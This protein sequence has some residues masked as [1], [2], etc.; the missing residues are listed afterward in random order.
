MAARWVA[1][2]LGLVMLGIVGF[3]VGAVVWPPAA[4]RPSPAFG[5]DGSEARAAHAVG[6]A[7][8]WTV[9]AEVAPAQAGAV[10]I[11][12]SIADAEGRPADPSTRPTA[13]LRMGDDMAMGSEVVNLVPQAP[14][15]WRGSGR[16]SMAGRWRLELEVEGG[17]IMLPLSP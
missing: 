10:E 13:V 12:V 2:A 5:G 4:P 1:L 17:R 6:Q 8:R 7:G 14:G 9:T 3:F 11:A 16:P 15:R